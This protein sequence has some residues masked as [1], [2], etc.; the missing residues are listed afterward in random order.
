M[1]PTK[2]HLREQCAA[3]LREEYKIYQILKEVL[4]NAN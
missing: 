3:I 1:R 4:Y 2:T